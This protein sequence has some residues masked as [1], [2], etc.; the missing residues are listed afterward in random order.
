MKFIKGVLVG[1]AIATGITMMYNDGMI[2]KRKIIK[3]G[4]QM[5]K[6]MGIYM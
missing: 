2:N 5:A 3:A 1:T 4:K 6:K